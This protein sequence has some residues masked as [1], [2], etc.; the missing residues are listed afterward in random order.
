MKIH[1]LRG[2]RVM[3]DFDLA[4]V[5]GVPTMRLNEQVSRNLSRFPQDFMFRLGSAEWTALISQIAISN[6]GR[7]GRRKPPRAF[8]EHGAVMLAAVLN[9]PVAVQ[10]SVA[11]VRAFNRMRHLGVLHKELARRLRRAET[12]LDGHDADLRAVLSALEQL[13][14]PEGGGDGKEI[15]FKPS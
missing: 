1:V 14:G 6:G 8:T 4:K 3:L 2:R 13:T 10:A 12:R 15:G 5:Y 9:T 7:G 11:I